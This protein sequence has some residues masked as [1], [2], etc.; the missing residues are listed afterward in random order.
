MTAGL[1]G[2]GIGG[3]FYLLG[4]VCMP[5]RETHRLLR[6]K[7][8][9]KRWILITKQWGLSLGIMAGFWLMG[10]MLTMIIPTGVQNA[11]SASSHNVLK[12]KAF[13]ISLSVLLS[14][15]TFVELSRFFI[16]KP[17]RIV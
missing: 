5:I 3:I 14:V 11:A 8:S 17:K 15:L 9:L 13:A 10:Y 1:P 6:G 4:V 12:V 7:S 16:P 2:T